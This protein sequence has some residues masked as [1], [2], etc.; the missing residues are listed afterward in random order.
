MIA[1]HDEVHWQHG[2]HSFTFGGEGQYHQYSFVSKIGGTCSG[3]AGCFTF[4]DNQTASD[5]TYWGQDGNSFAA[6]LIG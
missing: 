1:L 6:F 5:T 2:A 4:W 3:N